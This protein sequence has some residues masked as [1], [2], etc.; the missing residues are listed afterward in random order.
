MAHPWLCHQESGEGVSGVIIYPPRG[1][2]IPG[3]GTR[4]VGVG[5]ALNSVGS[6]NTSRTPPRLSLAKGLAGVER[7]RDGPVRMIAEGVSFTIG[8]S[9]ED[10]LSGETEDR[11]TAEEGFSSCSSSPPKISIPKMDHRDCQGQERNHGKGAEKNR[12]TFPSF[13]SVFEGA[14]SGGCR[15]TVEQME[16]IDSVHLLSHATAYATL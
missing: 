1:L 7:G 16:S 14:A 4:G 3:A 13:S 11:E 12:T 6:S 5:G 2:P 9:S 15:V 10:R 8:S